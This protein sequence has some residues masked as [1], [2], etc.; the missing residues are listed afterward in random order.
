MPQELISVIIP[1]Y[2][3]S[4]WLGETL[5]SLKSQTYTNFQA[6][7]V[8]DGST[9]SSPDICRSICDSDS[10]FRLIQQ[11]N[12]GVS[13]ARNSGIDIAEGRWIC[14][15]DSDDVMPKY[16]L[17]ALHEA[18][19]ISKCLI[20]VGNFIRSGD[21][22]A[23]TYLTRD[24][25]NALPLTVIPSEE[26]IAMGL[27]QKKILNNPWGVLFHTS[28]FKGTPLLRFRDC[29]YEDLDLFYRTFERTDKI[30]LLDLPVYIYRDNPASFINTWSRARLDAL[31]VTDRI[32]A[33]MDSKSKLLQRAAR[34]RRFSAHY[35]IL[36][37]MLRHGI[38]LRTQKERC[39]EVIRESR[40]DEL[41]D[42]EVRL[43]NKLGA[44]ASYFG[45]PA[46]RVLC[47]LSH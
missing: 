31:D 14:F 38:S 3:A 1:I 18:C 9:D 5:D 16:A 25:R 47:K 37:L 32:V 34:D 36:L 43:K 27:Y 12:R 26:A 40:F 33:H 41:R 46:I 29:R 7:L 10:R 19:T 28:I 8:D 35:N 24:P 13:I 15:M 39:L 45:L 17:E 11:P 4:G 2:N 21:I 44:L 30:C 23:G 22:S 20:T 42:P 6:I